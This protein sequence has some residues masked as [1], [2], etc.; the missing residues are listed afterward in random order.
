M[1]LPPSTPNLLCHSA[2]SRNESC[3]AG[4][5]GFST[6]RVMRRLSSICMMPSDCASAR[7][8]GMVAMVT[9]APASL[10]SAIMRRKSM[11]NS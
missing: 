1:L 5:L 11:R 8:T 4:S 3:T 10:C 6:N 7:P 9:S 2:G